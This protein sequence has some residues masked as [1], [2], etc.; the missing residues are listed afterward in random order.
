[1]RDSVQTL[2]SVNPGGAAFPPG[3]LAGR[4]RAIPVQ[5]S[6]MGPIVFCMEQS[7]AHDD[8]TEVERQLVESVVS[9]IGCDLAPGEQIDETVMRGWGASKTVRASVIRDVLRGCHVE[10]PD[11]HGVQLR[12]VKIVGRLDL[13]GMTTGVS[14]TLTAC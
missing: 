14:L 4:I 9:G 5:F 6:H 2:V 7:P 12:G 3:L 10:D 13:E 8:L 1:V 11:P